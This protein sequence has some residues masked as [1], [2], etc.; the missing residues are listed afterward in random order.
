MSR[1][2]AVMLIGILSIGPALVACEQPATESAVG[3]REL[4]RAS[5]VGADDLEVVMGLIERRGES[6][7][8]KH[9]HP[10]GE[11]GFVVQGALSVTS[12]DT[13]ETSLGAGMSF[14]QPP[15]EW[16]IVRTAAEGSRTVVFRVV[17]KGQPMIVNVE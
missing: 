8:T 10:A 16:H 17:E 1:T 2:H 5:I 14:H 15:G 11:T 13:P 9:Y 6:V 12:K 4:H 3:F 7:S